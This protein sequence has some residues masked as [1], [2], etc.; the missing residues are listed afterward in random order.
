MM[1]FE[2]YNERQQK[3]VEA[4]KALFKYRRESM[5]LMYGDY[6]T[7]YADDDVY[8]FLRHYMGEWVVVALNIR[9]EARAVEVAMPEFIASEEAK[10][11][12]STQGATA[13]LAEGKLTITVPKYGYVIIAK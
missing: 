4:T 3:E 6:R 12:L 10:V 5:P 13:A 9:A 1:E 7:L 2:G 11:A 8:V